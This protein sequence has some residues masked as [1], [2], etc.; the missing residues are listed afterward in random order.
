MMSAQF[1]RFNIL[2]NIKNIDYFKE[3]D[4]FGD[5][6]KY[7]FSG[8]DNKSLYKCCNYCATIANVKTK[9]DCF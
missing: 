2:F 3:T 8:E 6:I 1:M 4:Y 7:F 9:P 5:Y